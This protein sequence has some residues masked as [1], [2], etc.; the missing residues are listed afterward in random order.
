MKLFHLFFLWVI[1]IICHSH[2]N[3]NDNNILEK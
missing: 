3:N 1:S 2:K